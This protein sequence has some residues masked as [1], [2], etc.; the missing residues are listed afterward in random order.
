MDTV[1]VEITVTD[2][3]GAGAPT[4]GAPTPGAPAPGAPAPGPPAPPPVTFLPG[5][6]EM[7]TIGGLPALMQESA[8]KITDLHFVTE[9][10]LVV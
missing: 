3:A 4:P 9:V 7:P 5:A 2:G 8:V 1:T 10:L 6:G